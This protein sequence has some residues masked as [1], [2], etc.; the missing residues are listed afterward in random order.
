[1]EVPPDIEGDYL[2]ARKAL[3]ADGCTGEKRNEYVKFDNPRR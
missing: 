1:M 2:I 3:E